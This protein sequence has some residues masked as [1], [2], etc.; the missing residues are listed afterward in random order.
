M[1]FFILGCLAPAFAVAFL[2]TAF[3]RWFSP[4][5]GLIDRPAARKV[6]RVATPLGGGIGIWC[7]VIVPLAIMQILLWQSP[8]LVSRWLPP[9]LAPHLSGAVSRAPQLWTVL[10]GATVLAVMG[11]CDDFRPLPWPPRMALQ[12]AVAAGVVWSGVRATV[13]LASPWE[14]AALSML[15][16]AVLVNSFNFLDNMDGLSGGIGLIVSSIFAGMMLI[17]PGEPRWLVAGFF[18]VLAGSLAGFLCHNWT[19]AKIFMGDAGSYFI[20]FSIA[21]MTVLGTFYTPAAGNQHVILAPFCV[22]AIPLYD[23]ASVI[24]IRLREGRS[25]FHPDKR[26]FSHRLVAMGLRPVSA[27][28]TVHLA[29]LTTGLG[30]LVLYFVPTWTAA[31]APLAMV[32]CVVLIIAVLEAAPGQPPEA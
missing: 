27:V 5:V 7:G 21:A 32:V 15:W 24:A 17:A 29:T 22:L 26:H 20:G 19:P 12:L 2:A 31:I 30:G 6:H 10:G 14:G 16:F 18:L 4:R 28:L 23:I 11:L 13:F 25:P 3:L 8:E 9:E 1:W